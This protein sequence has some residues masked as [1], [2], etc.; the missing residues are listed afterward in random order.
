MVTRIPSEQ[1]FGQTLELLRK[2]ADFSLYRGWHTIKSLPVLVVSL[3][4]EQSSPQAVR[5]QEHEYSL[6]AELDPS[7]AAKPLEL[8]C[9]ESCTSIV[10]MDPGGEPLD[11]VL[12]R[13][14][15]HSFDLTRFLR[16]AIGMAR[17]LG[18]MHR[19]GLIHKDIKPA[20]VLV[21]ENGS[22]WF[23]GF[24][25]AS[26]LPHERQAPAP[27]EIIAGTLAYMAP[28]QTGRMNRSMDSRSDLYSLGITMYQI[29]TGRLPFAA[30]DALEWRIRHRQH[31]IARQKECARHRQRD[32]AQIIQHAPAHLKARIIRRANADDSQSSDPFRSRN[33]PRAPRRRIIGGAAAQYGNFMALRQR[34]CHGHGHFCGRGSVR[35]KIEVK[36]ENPHRE[37]VQGSRA[38]CGPGCSAASGASIAGGG[39]GL[40][41]PHAKAAQKSISVRAEACFR[42]QLF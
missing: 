31:H 12:D 11:L 32:V 18:K 36:Q 26:R 22:A 34:F 8:I 33:A 1:P 37:I 16:I 19:Q 42:R 28:E 6:A 24:G 4:G 40:L 20:N 15:G 21:S 5:R 38:R 14:K 7:W 27:P 10:L 30:D 35:R 23:T 25:I 41:F 2:G 9:Q 39:D 13:E 29:L 17:S 3:D